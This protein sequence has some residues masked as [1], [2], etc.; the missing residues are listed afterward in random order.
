MCA[1]AHRGIRE[2][3]DI[4]PAAQASRCRDAHRTP[5]RDEM[6]RTLANL[7]Y[8]TS[9]LIEDGHVWTHG[10]G[11]Q[12]RYAIQHALGFQ[13]WELDEPR[14]LHA[15]GRAL[16]GYALDLKGTGAQDRDQEAILEIALVPITSGHPDLASAFAT[17]INPGRPVPRKPWIS[18]GLTTQTL[19][20]A[21]SIETTTAPATSR[22]G[23]GREF[24]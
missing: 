1:R 3:C 21:P 2:L 20:R 19:A 9:Y 15:H 12:R 8:H 14:L 24:R 22:P 7:G 13:I 10:L 4:C 6:D 16:T 11:E 17:M 18:P 5:G 23:P